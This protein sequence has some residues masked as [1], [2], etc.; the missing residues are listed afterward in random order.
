MNYR[1]RLI[2]DKVH[3]ALATFPVV[4]L[5]GARQTGKKMIRY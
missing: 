5:A 1:P 2:A 3:A 4:V